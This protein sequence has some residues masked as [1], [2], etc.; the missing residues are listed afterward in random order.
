MRKFHSLIIA[1]V[2]FHPVALSDGIPV[3]R[4]TMKITVPN[5]EIRLSSDQIEEL[6]VLGT[7]T[8]TTKQLKSLAE[9]A[10]DTP[11]RL[12]RILSLD[13]SGCTCG[14]DSYCIQLDRDR[15]AILNSSK[16][17]EASLWEMPNESYVIL[18]ADSKGLFYYK[19]MKV[20]FEVLLD[21]VGRRPEPGKALSSP[22][23]DILLPMGMRRDDPIVK[24]HIK[25]LFESA[26]KA[27][28]EQVQEE[29]SLEQAT[30]A[31]QQIKRM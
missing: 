13:Y 28:R 22:S 7:V 30:L 17:W 26:A 31:D 21:W 19:G 3:D 1:F 6:E 4:E 14:P 16:D 29:E 10:P 12:E 18:R 25:Q 23:L 27:G 5:T 11:K 24:E 2:L 9:V 20:P 8:L 15:I